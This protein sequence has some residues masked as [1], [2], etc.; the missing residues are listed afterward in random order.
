MVQTNPPFFHKQ[1]ERKSILSET[2]GFGSHKSWLSLKTF[3]APFPPRRL[4]TSRLPEHAYSSHSLKVLTGS[5]S[6]IRLLSYQLSTPILFVCLFVAVVVLR[7]SKA[8]AS[9]FRL[10]SSYKMFST[11][12]LHFF[13]K[14]QVSNS[15]H[16]LNEGK[17]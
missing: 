7:P 10:F 4:T 3:V 2:S 6:P 5:P 14:L 1:T 15:S 17:K 11:I 8:F 9:S 16:F 12:L 13:S